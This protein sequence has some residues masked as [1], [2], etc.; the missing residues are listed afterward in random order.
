MPTTKSFEFVECQHCAN[1]EGSVF[2]NMHGE[3]LETISESKNCTVFK[4]GQIIFHEGANPYGVYCI[5]QGK[6]KLSI[7]GDEG[8]EQIV[9]LAGDGDLLGYRS[10]LVGERYNATAVAL[11]D[12]KVCYISRDVF[13]PAVKQDANLSFE[14][15]KLLSK[16]LKEAEV[17]LTHLAQKSVRERLAET[18]LFLKETYGYE[19]DS[20][21]LNVRLSREEIAN[22]VGTATETVIRLLSDFN[23]EGL[24]LLEGK[25]IMMANTKKL[26]QVANLVD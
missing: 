21:Y 22:L 20:T 18:L 6:I 25:R 10:M 4:K 7:V 2:C 12:S 16:Q 17:K 11:E 23:K 9:R 3:H 19:A 1:R 13:L 24:V 14:M 5:K 8:R 26:A 15:L